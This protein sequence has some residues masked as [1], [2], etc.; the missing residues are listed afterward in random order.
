[1]LGPLIRVLVVGLVLLAAISVMTVSFMGREAPQPVQATLF[2]E[3]RPLPEFVLTDQAGEP[4][5]R[6]DMTGHYSL[7]FFGFTNCPDICPL[8]LQ[9]LADVRARLAA[10]KLAAPDVVFI[11]V[12]PQR[13]SPSAISDY[14]GYYDDQMTGLVGPSRS[15]KPLLDFFGVA[16]HK[17]E[18][19]GKTYNM[20]HTGAIFVVGPDAQ[21]RGVFSTPGLA[22]EVLR[23]FLIIR[24]A[25]E[26]S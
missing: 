1:M 6:S 24:R 18:S 10:R 5:R 25:T 2:P 13:D 9:I 19:A 26:A 8:T 17:M 16:V 15:L 14:L 11:S 12:D 7:V 4:F 22:D 20:T 23:D 21:Y 3:P